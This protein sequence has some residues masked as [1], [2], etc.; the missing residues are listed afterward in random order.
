MLF[1]NLLLLDKSIYISWILSVFTVHI[2]LSNQK[3]QLH[4]MF[5][6]DVIRANLKAKIFKC[7]ILII[8][9]SDLRAVFWGFFSFYY[10]PLLCVCTQ[11]AQQQPQNIATWYFIYRHFLNNLKHRE[12]QYW[13]FAFFADFRAIFRVSKVFSSVFPKFEHICKTMK[14]KMTILML[15]KIPKA[16][17]SRIT[18]CVL[19]V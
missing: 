13:T 17:G 11:F 1:I 8:F 18:N 4:E 2:F 5:T 14:F 6:L 12:T 3:S 9:F 19:G 16:R 7:L 10:S 15:L